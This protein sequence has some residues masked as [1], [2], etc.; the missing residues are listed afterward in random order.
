MS[1]SRFRISAIL[2]VLFSTTLV[3]CPLAA[4][5]VAKTVESAADDD[6]EYTDSQLPPMGVKEARKVLVD[7]YT[8]GLQRKLPSFYGVRKFPDGSLVFVWTDHPEKFSG[9]VLKIKPPLVRRPE[10]EVMTLGRPYF[11]VHLHFEE[12]CAGG[13]KRDETLFNF[14]QMSTEKEIECP[15]A[16]TYYA[17]GE[18]LKMENTKNP[19]VYIW[20][21]C[22]KDEENDHCDKD[23]LEA[24]KQMTLRFISAVRVLFPL[25]K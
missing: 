9:F 16:G 5:V 23:K 18:Y 6:F 7:T 22:D 3:G 24:A 14:G 8:K 17:S 10:V 2:I 11:Q 15:S 12:Y 25:K 4:F 21:P 13:V 20:F 1:A 19:K